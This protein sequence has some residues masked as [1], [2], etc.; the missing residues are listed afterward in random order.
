M[1]NRKP[2]IE[3]SEGER[4]E[5]GLRAERAGR[6]GADDREGQQERGVM[7]GD[8]GVL[9][10]NIYDAELLRRENETIFVGLLLTFGVVS[11]SMRS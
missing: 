6:Q 10:V 4:G 3:E 1:G 8:E 7:K 11:H 5:T 2:K 9:A